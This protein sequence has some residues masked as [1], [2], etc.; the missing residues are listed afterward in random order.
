VLRPMNKLC[1]DAV[2][3]GLKMSSDLCGDYAYED[4]LPESGRMG[5]NLTSETFTWYL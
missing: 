4:V 3:V 1:S 5:S 2:E